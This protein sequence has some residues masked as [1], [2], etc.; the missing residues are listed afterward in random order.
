M[1]LDTMGTM[2]VVFALGILL[3]EMIEGKEIME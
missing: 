3:M 2:V 1:L